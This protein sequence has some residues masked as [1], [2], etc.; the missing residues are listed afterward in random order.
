M[1]VQE[2]VSIR[3][4]LQWIGAGIV[5]A[6]VNAGAGLDAIEQA[7]AIGIGVKGIGRRR[8]TIDHAVDLCAIAGAVA[9]GISFRRICAES[10]FLSVRQSI[11]VA[12][13]VGVIRVI[14]VEATGITRF[15]DI[16]K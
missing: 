6:H 15:I 8:N 11:S 5:R 3:I 12:I 1:G 2:A 7:V 13:G 16:G 14:G 9:V 4:F 10:I